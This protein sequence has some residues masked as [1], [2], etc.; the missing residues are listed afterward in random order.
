[1]GQTQMVDTNIHM[2]SI[3]REDLELMSLAGIKAVISTVGLVDRQADITS[4]DCFSFYDRLLTFHS[5]RASQFC[6]DTYICVGICMLYIPCDWE[7]VIEG[8]PDYL[9]RERVVGVGEVGLEPGSIFDLTLQEEVLRAQLNVAK[10]CGK[11]AIIHIPNTE[12]PKWVER[13]LKITQE[14]KLEPSKVV[15]EHCDASVVKMIT[16][17][18]CNAGLTVQPW[19]KHRPEDAARIVKEGANLD[20]LLLS[21]DCNFGLESDPLSVPKT[22]FEMRKLGVGESDIKKVVWENPRRVYSLG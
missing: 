20:Q 17:S 12:K 11:P 4:G 14:Q 8:L 5:W 2:E 1:M 19:R 10:K 22:V 13:F 6:I 3:N 7:K 16:D 9:G 15:L 18:G 21:G